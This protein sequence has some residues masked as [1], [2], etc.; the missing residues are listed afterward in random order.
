MEGKHLEKAD[1]GPAD[2]P[3]AFPVGPARSWMPLSTSPA[4]TQAGT[5]KPALVTPL[6]GSWVLP[7]GT[8]PPLPD[9]GP[10]PGGWGLGWG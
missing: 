5:H 9:A 8:Q 1:K 4:P 3:W 2:A 6:L 10:G 7:M